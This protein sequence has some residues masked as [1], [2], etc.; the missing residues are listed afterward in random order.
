MK[1]AFESTALLG[2]KTGV[3]EFCYRAGLALS[4]LDGVELSAFAVSWRRRRLLSDAVGDSIR[5]RQLAMP[6]RPLQAIWARSRF[7]P[8]EMF[9]GRTD[10][11]HGT[12]FVVPPALWAKRVVTVH[13]L[14]PVLYPQV[15]Q[16]ATL[17]FPA[18]IRRAVADGAYVHTPSEFVAREVV[19]HFRA[20]PSRVFAVHHGLP[21]IDSAREF[22]AGELAEF[23][24]IRALGG[25]P[26]LLGLGTIEP[27]KDFG[28]LLGAFE[29]LGS[30]WPDLRLVIAGPE[31]WGSRPLRN[32]IAASPFRDRVVLPGYVTE[33]ERNW[34][35]SHAAVFA[36]PSIYEGF[37]FPPIEAMRFATPV[38]SS[39]AGSLPEVLGD[40]A[41]F[42][43]PGDVVALAEGLSALIDDSSLR[44]AQ[45][46][47]ASQWISR[48]SWERSALG[49][50]RIYRAALES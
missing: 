7:P 47:R 23:G 27:R 35:I 2:T 50:E 33:R 6:A 14:T 25:A 1:V 19:E 36:Y 29:L 20:D 37:G 17:V 49:L 44:R 24:T 32:A 8:I 43:A 3:G 15:A 10:I 9:V 12:N 16:A 45:I 13:D 21:E 4:R 42:F 28:T 48:Y 18:L 5:V 39:N 30:T 40:G 11:V 31:G 34:L 38:I 26:F 41:M 46:I 22:T